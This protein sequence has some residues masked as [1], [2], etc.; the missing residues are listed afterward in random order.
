MALSLSVYGNCFDLES[1]ARVNTSA[2][3][4]AQYLREWQSQILLKYSANYIFS[5]HVSLRD[6]TDIFL[7]FSKILKL[8]FHKLERDK[9][10]ILLSVWGPSALRAITW[11]ILILLN[12]IIL[13]T[14]GCS[15]Y[16]YFFPMFP[17]SK[18]LYYSF[19]WSYYTKEIERGKVV[20]Q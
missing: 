8:T 12:E 17:N 5:F 20:I 2:A 18:N 1:F 11:L 3:H 14:L 16:I 7:I 6:F 13:T 10:G 4:F 9:K 15:L 19:V